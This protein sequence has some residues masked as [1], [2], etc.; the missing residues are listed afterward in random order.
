M[1]NLRIGIGY[2]VHQLESGLPFILGGFQLE[3]DR[4][5]VAHSDGDILYHA[6]AD[7]LLGAA[8]LG[9]IGHFFP[10]DDPVREYRSDGGD[11][12]K[13][14][15]RTHAFRGGHREPLLPA[16]GERRSGAVHRATVDLS[17]VSMVS[18]QKIHKPDEFRGHAKSDTLFHHIFYLNIE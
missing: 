3:S 1:T 11:R 12:S 14:R 5:V 4:G 7:A 10:D 16:D 13:L 9:D 6:I 2:D 15:A 18:R 8:A 17:E